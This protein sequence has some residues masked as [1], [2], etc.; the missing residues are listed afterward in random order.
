VV[1][2]GDGWFGGWRGFINNFRL[3][4]LPFVVRL[5]ISHDKRVVRINPSLR[6]LERNEMSKR[7]EIRDGKQRCI[8][9]KK[10]K[11]FDDEHFQ[12]SASYASGRMSSCR[13]CRSAYDK[14][15]QK[16]YVKPDRVKVEPPAAR[17]GIAVEKDI[18]H[19]PVARCRCGNE[20]FNFPPHLIGV[21]DVVCA[22]CRDHKYVT[23]EDIKK[24]EI[25]RVG[26]KPK[27][28]EEYQFTGRGIERI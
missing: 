10:W 18:E 27:K 7:A 21:V 23:L 14:G 6:T 9:C 28:R 24:A 19:A 13:V 1:S 25:P 20:V 17:G 26:N 5:Y 2:T 4:S 3:G 8:K 11:P 16:G 15:R 12:P 22:E